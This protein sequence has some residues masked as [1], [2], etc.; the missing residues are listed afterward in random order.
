MFTQ[1]FEELSIKTNGIKLIKIT[2]K[3]LN[4]IDRSKIT[5]G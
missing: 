4:F 1:S 3:I 2:E 5:N